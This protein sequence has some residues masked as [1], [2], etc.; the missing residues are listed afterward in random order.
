FLVDYPQNFSSPGL[1][2]KKVEY[3]ADITS[4]R[5]KVLPELD[6]EWA[7]SLG[8]FDSLE[9]VRTKLREDLEGRATAEAAYN[10]RGEVVR[11]LVEAHQFEVPQSLVEQQTDH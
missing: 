2:G 11:K 4:V 3:R 9:A 8:E 5:K 7:K 1:A 10:L 6:D